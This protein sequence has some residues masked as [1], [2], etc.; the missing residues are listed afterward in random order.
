MKID[1]EL[2]VNGALYRASVRP[3][4]TLLDVLREHL[5]LTGTKRGCDSGK[6]G[7]CT[8]IMEGK[9]VKSCLTL[10]AKADGR[11]VLTIEGLANGEVLHPLQQAFIDHSAVQ[12]GFCSPG[13]LLAAKALLDENPSPTRQEVKDAITG[14][15]CRCTGYVRI[16]D[17]ILTAAQVSETRMNPEEQGNSR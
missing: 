17:A 4:E 5:F 7:V 15:L 12:C 10:A 2:T 16:V 13:M 11:E 3:T 1:I 6:C 8:V 9:A 14:N